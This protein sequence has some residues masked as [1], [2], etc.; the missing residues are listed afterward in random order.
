M[1]PNLLTEGVAVAGTWPGLTI[2]RFAVPSSTILATPNGRPSPVSCPLSVR[3][4]PVN[5]LLQHALHPPQSYLTCLHPPS[6]QRLL[7]LQISI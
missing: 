7:I 4:S 1:S 5:F 3:A 6:D 2:N